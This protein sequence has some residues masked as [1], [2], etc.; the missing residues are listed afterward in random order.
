V[1]KKKR[2]VKR[3]FQHVTVGEFLLRLQRLHSAGEIQ[4]IAVCAIDKQGDFYT[5]V[6]NMNA[7][8]FQL[9]LVALQ[10][11]YAGEAEERAGAPW[12]PPAL[13]S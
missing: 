11:E 4:K 10:Q 2:P 12:N 8:D 5:N 1:V 3:P 6:F 7:E 9:T 13:S